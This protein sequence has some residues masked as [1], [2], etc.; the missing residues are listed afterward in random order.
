MNWFKK[1]LPQNFNTC[2]SDK[3]GEVIVLILDGKGGEFSILSVLWLCEDFEAVFGALEVAS[4]V[5]V[6]VAVMI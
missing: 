3:K 1:P 2:R 4:L 5:S 6:L